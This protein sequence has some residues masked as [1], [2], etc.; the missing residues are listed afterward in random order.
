MGIFDWIPTIPEVLDS[1]ACLIGGHD[2]IVV[3]DVNGNKVIVCENCGA[4]K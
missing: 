4:R 1:T 3:K 2:W